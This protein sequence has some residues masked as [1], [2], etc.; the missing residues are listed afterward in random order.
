[1]AKRS[2]PSDKPLL[3]ADQL[4]EAQREI[5]E[6]LGIKAGWGGDDRWKL[7]K[8]PLGYASLD[9]ALNGGFAFDRM[10]LLYGAE[11]SGKTLLS[12]LAMKAAQRENL[13]VAFVDVEKTWTPEWAEAVG[14]DVSKVLVMRP[15][16]AEEAWRMLLVLVR[17]K[18]GLVVMDSLAAMAAAEELQGEED[19][20][21][22]KI[23]VGGTAKLNGQGLRDLMA[24][25]QGTLIILINQ[26]RSA[27]GGYG[28]PDV[29]P[30]G[31]AQDFWAWQKVKVRRG[32]WIE[33]GTGDSK[34]RIGY[35]LGITVE[36]NKQGAPFR[37]G[38]VPFYYTGEID[39][40]AGLI[41]QA[42]DCRIIGGKPPSYEVSTRD[43][44]I[45]KFYGKPK[46]LRAVKEDPDLAEFLRERIRDEVV[47]LD[48][49]LSSV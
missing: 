13:S 42:I 9:A 14:V 8:L 25:N 17:R 43:G 38:E 24:D 19:E 26:L 29:L 30:G 23:R 45:L 47:E 11:S 15:R 12:M 40:L 33:E 7:R 31:R 28:N 44:E 20:A 22:D 1:M 37:K 16:T 34:K 32:E 10:A 21:F 49:L 35:K 5:E 46:L 4:A 2:A 41:D 27:I 39:E 48:D 18:V 6:A 3:S 36:K